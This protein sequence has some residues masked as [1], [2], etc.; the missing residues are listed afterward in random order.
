MRVLAQRGA[1][2][3]LV[4]AASAALVFAWLARRT[5]RVVPRLAARA[6]QR[7]ADRQAPSMTQ[8]A[9]AAQAVPYRIEIAGSERA[10]ITSAELADRPAAL[11]ARDRRAWRLSELLPDA[12]IHSDSVIR[13]LTL[14]GKDYILRAAGRDGDDVLVVRRATGELYLGWL[15]DATPGLPLG[16]AERPAERIARV[17]RITVA[18]PT[19][20]PAL[21][22]A[23]LTVVIDGVARR[24]VTATSFAASARL[25]IQGPRDAAAPAIDVAHAFGDGLQIADMVADG[26][27]LTTAPPTPTARAVIYLTR[28]ARFKFAWIDA[29]GQPIRGTQQREL[30]E[31]ALRSPASR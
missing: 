12:Y 27:R 14:D 23:Q 3:I 28:R 7:G 20:P 26:A 18:A 10:A 25:T 21:P 24:I 22:A 16:D 8:V 2:A 5:D 15:D 6:A 31:I 1:V 19:A 11:A 30:T 9:S 17:A 4:A 13:A 29:A